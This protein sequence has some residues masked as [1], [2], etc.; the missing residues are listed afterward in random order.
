[1]I[2]FLQAQVLPPIMALAVFGL[3]VVVPFLA[4]RQLLDRHADRSRG[5]K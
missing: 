5:P 1:M 3:F 2:E 4:L